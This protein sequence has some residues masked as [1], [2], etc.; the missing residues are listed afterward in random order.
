MKARPRKLSST[1]ELPERSRPVTL[2]TRS[3]E[4]IPARVVERDSTS[5][6][7]AIMIQ[8]EHPLSDSQLHD[9]TLE[10]TCAK[11]RVRLRGDVTIEDRDLVRI[12]GLHPAELIQQREYYRV[13]A[14]RPVQVSVGARRV[15]V[16]SYSV[17]VSGSGLLLAGPDLL[18]IGEHVE[19]R[20]TTVAGSPPITGSGKV[21]RAD[22]RGHR[23]IAFD[24]IS[25]LDRRR[26]IRFVFECQR[27]E[28][29]RGLRGEGA[30][31]A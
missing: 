24:S 11:G 17:D 3:G 30:H 6:L 7:V 12:S 16:Q 15:L 2:A 14:A 31:G 19:F 9:L 8:L 25:D 21:V 28:R 29:R 18:K 27:A 20:L 13:K 26:L 1:I 23:A 10:F 5:L 4:R 22:V